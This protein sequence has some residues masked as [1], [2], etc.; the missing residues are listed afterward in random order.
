MKARTWRAL[1]VTGAI[2]LAGSA[3]ACADQGN[4]APRFERP[5]GNIVGL[6]E[7]ARL[8]ANGEFGG[9]RAMAEIASQFAPDSLDSN[10]PLARLVA[11]WMARRGSMT[12]TSATRMW[13]GVEEYDS[14]YYVWSGGQSY[15]PAHK[16][17]KIYNLIAQ[18]SRVG[19]DGPVDVIVTFKFDGHEASNDAS[20]TLSRSNGDAIR[21]RPYGSF[22]SQTDPFLNMTVFAARGW[23]AKSSEYEVGCDVKV[24]GS[25]RPKA[26]YMGKWDIDGV[27]VGVNPAGP[28]GS[29]NLTHGKKGEVEASTGLDTQFTCPPPGDG[30]GGDA[31]CYA[32][33][34]WF[35]RL[36]SGRVI[37]WWECS[38]TDPSECEGAAT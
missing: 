37:E 18:A 28:A 17:A 34:Q 31:D 35:Y 21:S 23:A 15:A 30:Y 6:D 12:G 3:C 33:Q 24:V 20:W 16:Q 13:S 22:G 1:R 38:Q 26:W 11:E 29:L 5:T 2:M 19:G 9:N 36:E 10:D 4:T 7:S 25:T 8:P 27:S 32:C 14:D